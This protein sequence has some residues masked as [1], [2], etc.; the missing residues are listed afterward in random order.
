MRQAGKRTL[1]VLLSLC[2]AMVCAAA[3]AATANA[4]DVIHVGATHYIDDM[5]NFGEVNYIR[6][7]DQSSSSVALSGEYQL[8]WTAY[9]AN[10]QQHQ[11]TVLKFN[12][13]G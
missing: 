7:D 4:D 9:L 6:N 3:M 10:F 13:T 8:T 12:A 11:F 5:V 2:V 1:R